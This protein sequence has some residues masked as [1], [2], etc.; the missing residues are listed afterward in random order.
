MHPY[1]V[2]LLPDLPILFAT[3]DEDYRIADH[4]EALAADI[5]VLLNQVP[6]PVYLVNDLSQ[7]HMPDVEELIFGGK[8]L[9]YG[10]DTVFHHPNTRE[11]LIVTQNE[12]LRVSFL[13]GIS[14]D[15]GKVLLTVFDTLD[16]AMAYVRT[17]YQ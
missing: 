11:I 8:V 6:S 1:S 15:F 12:I 2:Q 7:H 13:S 5:M 14:K 10:Y 3:V 4:V 9:S 16:D 17:R